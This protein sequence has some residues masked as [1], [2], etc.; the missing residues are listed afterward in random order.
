MEPSDRAGLQM[1]SRKTKILGRGQK[2]NI[3]INWKEIEE[4]EE[5]EYLGQLLSFEDGR[6]KEI[7]RHIER[8]W[9][10]FWKLE[11]IYKAKMGIRH[12]PYSN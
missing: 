11:T 1:D 10:S 3:I 2:K 8:G 6:E 7:R 4:V 12:R 5:V 9:R